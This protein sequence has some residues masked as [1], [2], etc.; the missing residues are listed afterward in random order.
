[1]DPAEFSRAVVYRRAY[2]LTL[3]RLERDQPSGTAGVR[4]PGPLL[5][6]LSREVEEELWGDPEARE[7]FLRRV[8]DATEGRRP[9]W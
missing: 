7:A 6:R 5:D 4:D 2:G 3:R 8:Q 1:M 9:A